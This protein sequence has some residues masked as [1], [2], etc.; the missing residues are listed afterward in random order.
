MRGPAHIAMNG[1][2]LENFRILFERV[3]GREYSQTLIMI[4]GT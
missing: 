2:G 1:K 4:S 3:T